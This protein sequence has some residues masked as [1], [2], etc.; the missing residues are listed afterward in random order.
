MVNTSAIVLKTV[1]Y[2]DSGLICHLFTYTSGVQ[3][4]IL[5]GV[6]SGKSRSGKS[7]IL[8]PGALL[9]ISYDAH[10]NRQMQYLKDF[11]IHVDLPL[12]QERVVQNCIR[13]FCIEVMSHLLIE[14]QEQ[15]ELFEWYLDFFREVHRVDNDTHLAN[16]PLYFLIRTAEISGYSVSTNFDPEHAPFFNIREGAFTRVSDEYTVLDLNESRALFELIQCK[17]NLDVSSILINNTSRRNILN[18]FLAFL[19]FHTAA[20]RELKCLKV[21]QMVLS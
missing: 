10:P 5:K 16:Y 3:V 21:L 8:F 7:N 19:Q 13:M 12:I 2:G 14:G 11:Q 9:E 20:F 4:F 15:P 17:K 18:Q 6:F 1:K